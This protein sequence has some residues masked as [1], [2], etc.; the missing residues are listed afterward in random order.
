MHGI[1]LPR[2]SDL[3]ARTGA[4]IAV[5]LAHSS[6]RAGDLLYFAESGDRVTHVAVSLGGSHIIHSALGNGGVDLNDLAGGLPIEQRLN[7]MFVSARR[8]LAD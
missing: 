3:Q 6:L 2:D 7:A 1:A 4:G 5:D 8:M